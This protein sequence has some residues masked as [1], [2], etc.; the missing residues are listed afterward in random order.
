MSDVTAHLKR[1]ARDEAGRLL[2][3]WS[4]NLVDTVN[5][6]FL[7]EV[8]ADG[9]PVA[10]AP[11]SIILN[12]R[13][14]WFFSAAARALKSDEALVLASRASDYLHRYFIDAGAGGV[15][16][17]LDAQ[18][19][20]IDS[21]KQAY[22]QAFTVY[23]LAEY[24]LASHDL[25]ALKMAEALQDMIEARFW[26]SGRGGYIEA[27]DRE[28]RPLADPR[29]SEKDIDAPKTMNTHLH[30]L[31]A[32]TSLHRAAPRQATQARLDRI[33]TLFLD[34]FSHP[35]GHLRLFFDMDWTDRTAGVSYGHDIEASWLIWEAAQAL[36]DDALRDRC[37]PVVL[38]L[39]GTTLHE[40]LSPEGGMNY[41][42]RFDGHFD[43]DGEWWEQAE[44]LVGFVNAWHMTGEPGWLDAADRVWAYTKAQ[45]GAGGRREWS[46]YAAA[47]GREKIYTAGMW[48]CPYHN[49]RAM[50]ELDHRLG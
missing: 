38:A 19:R 33:L 21:K 4:D 41:E 10:D 30:I 8:D 43:P 29:L 26:D 20:V 47:S 34:R 7:G 14:L 50:I 13:L 45:Y 18:G 16:W 49:G 35:Q 2:R 48:K 42:K 6:G 11:K 17:L 39:A 23:A 37:R 25:I 31:E 36:D 12:T 32:Y 40:G 3:W 28:W 9:L 24:Y 1:Q 44:A 27:L 15:Y 46:W 5:G 22:A